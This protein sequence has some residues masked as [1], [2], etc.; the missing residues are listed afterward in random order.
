MRRA[1]NGQDADQRDRSASNQQPGNK[2]CSRYLS[3][4]HARARARHGKNENQRKHEHTNDEGCDVYGY[5]A[6][7]L[8]GKNA[9]TK[10]L[11]ITRV[12]DDRQ[13]QSA[14]TRTSRNKLV[15]T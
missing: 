5:Q 13:R 15:S 7:S 12:F 3:G 9:R 6:L 10:L 11:T 1:G 8:I 14:G 4:E 2:R